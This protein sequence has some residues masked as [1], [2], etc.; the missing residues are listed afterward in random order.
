MLVDGAKVCVSAA[1]APDSEPADSTRKLTKKKEAEAQR[2]AEISRLKSQV[3]EAAAAANREQTERLEEARRN[4]S[5]VRE[6]YRK[7][8][9]PPRAE[10]SQQ[11][12]AVEREGAWLTERAAAVAKERG[13]GGGEGL[14]GIIAARERLPA[15]LHRASILEAVAQAQVVVISGETGC[16]KTTQVPQ[17]ILEDAVAT[18]GG[19]SCNIVCTQPRRIS[20]IG[21]AERVAAERGERAGESSGYAIKGETRRGAHT[22]VLF[23]TVGVLLRRLQ[24]EPQLGSVTHLIVDEVHERDVL[25]DFLLV[26]IRDLLPQRPDLK[27]VLMSATLSASSFAE[28]F[29][30]PNA[31]TVPTISIPGFT[32]PVT[33]LFLEDII[34]MTGWRPQQA[35]EASAPAELGEKYS[36]Q[37]AQAVG[38]MRQDDT[39]YDL[40]QTTLEHIC[41]GKRRAGSQADAPLVPV[42][43]ILVF[44][45]GLQEIRKL[46]DALNASP[47]F[48]DQQRYVVLGLHSSLDSRSQRAIFRK[49]RFNPILIRFN[50]I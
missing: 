48:G 16:G 25:T 13:R 5:R 10:A 2:E 49:V 35:V 46:C 31:P 15:F 26:I 45:P 4:I 9:R 23:C 12:A 33:D 17:F 32:F 50:P 28:Y 8:S 24:S 27:L 14:G 47:L 11:A 19:G 40:I 3:A 39:D 37:T 42:G 7:R 20:A 21:V 38:A 41:S 43:G 34:Q 36:A 6:A 44:L 1:A 18:G 30:L 29:A 22:R